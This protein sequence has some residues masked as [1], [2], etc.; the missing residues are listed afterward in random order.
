MSRFKLNAS[1]AALVTSDVR[2]QVGVIFRLTLIVQPVSPETIKGNARY[3]PGATSGCI[4]Q[5]TTDGD[6]V[7][8]SGETGVVFYPTIVEHY[9]LMWPATREEIGPPL[10]KLYVC[11]PRTVADWLK[12][13]EDGVAKEGLYF[14]AGPYKGNRLNEVW[15]IFG[16][17]GDHETEFRFQGKAVPIGRDMARQASSA[18]VVMEGPDGKDKRVYG[19]PL[20]C[21]RITTER[22]TNA[23]G[24]YYLPV[25]EYLGRLGEVAGPTF[26]QWQALQERRLSKQAELVAAGMPLLAMHV[27]EQAALTKH[28]DKEDDGSNLPS[29]VAP[30]PLA[31]DWTPPAPPEPANDQYDERSPPPADEHDY[32]GQPEPWNDEIPF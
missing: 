6:R 27:P 19:A 14:T 17:I 5:V 26:E 18:S 10:A 21:F 13:E 12:P 22:K 15:A 8:H 2:D 11:P 23:L 4:V 20:T 31:R 25:V 30:L 29:T 9:W 1:T 32:A 3:T 16:V 28:A 7:V 24:T